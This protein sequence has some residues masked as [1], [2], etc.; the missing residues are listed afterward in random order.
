MIPTLTSDGLLPPGHYE[1]TVEE[2]RR[3]FIDPYPNTN[4][5]LL[6]SEWLA[7]NKRLQAILNVDGVIQWIDGSFVSD[8]PNPGDIDVVT[9]ISHTIYESLENQLVEFYSTVALYNK[10]LDAYV[11]PVYPSAHWHYELFHQLRVD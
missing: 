1:C 3:H 2:I 7:Y 4:R 11:C 10:G 6:F 9:F 8:K 5:H